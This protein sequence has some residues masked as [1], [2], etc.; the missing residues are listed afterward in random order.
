MTLEKPQP[1]PAPATGAQRSSLRSLLG[2]WGIVVVWMG[3]IS[4]MS[5]EAF[6][7][8]N[9]NHYLDPVLRFFFP[10][11]TLAGFTLAHTVIRKSA[12]F[13]EFFV[14]GS[15][16][17]WACRRG[18]APRWRRAWMWQALGL[19]V[20]YALIDE[21]HQAFVPNRTPSLADSSVDSFGA[22][23]SQAV[24]Y[25]RHLLLARTALR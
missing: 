11:M 1:A 22:A 20:L 8:S 13:T 21:A 18:R 6:S 19:A 5:G 24:I 25:L 14:L 9:T 3:A 17:Y 4:L 23:V 16:T 15:L 10:H 2:Y 12:H 7:A